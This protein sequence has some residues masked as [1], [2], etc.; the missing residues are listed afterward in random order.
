[1]QF[2]SRADNVIRSTLYKAITWQRRT[3]KTRFDQ[4]YK[5]S[6]LKRGKDLRLRTAFYKATSKFY[7]DA[8]NK[9]RVA[10]A[11]L[12]VIRFNNEEGPVRMETNLIK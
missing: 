5:N 10:A 1:M 7:R 12:E 6:W 3:L 9:W 11:M 4:F 2:G 8:F